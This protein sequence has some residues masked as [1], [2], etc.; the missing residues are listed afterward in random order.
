[1]AEFFHVRYRGGDADQHELPA[2]HLAASLEG[3]DRI[4]VRAL[5]AIET[6]APSKRS[7]LPK[8]LGVSVRAPTAGCLDIS[9]YAT[10]ATA[11][12][13]FVAS[14]HEAVRNKLCEHIVSYTV[15]RW[16]GRKNE[17]ENNLGAAMDI[18]DA[19]NERFAEDRKHER[20]AA[21]EDRQREREH[22]AGLLRSQA[23]SQR[24]DA[25]KAV[26][27]VGVSCRNM[28]ISHEDQ[29]TEFDEAT[30][31]AVKAKEE[32][33]VSEVMDMTVQVDGIELSS[34]T[35]KVFDPDRPGK[36]VNVHISDPAFDPL[37]PGENPYETAVNERRRIRLT[38]KATRKADGT[39]R[40]FHA[41]SA[42]AI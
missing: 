35:L 9:A 22:I 26:Q 6:S 7:P 37:H 12:M 42:L 19:Q 34:K 21:Y 2:R 14:M 13:P 11:V 32:L 38:G 25:R 23:D 27:P 40:S 17:A 33:S 28:L 10:V 24:G 15:L 5:W 1:M 30:A 3:I 31:E 41:I 20:D 18:I 29:K 36:R 8:T 16:G 39:L 4:V